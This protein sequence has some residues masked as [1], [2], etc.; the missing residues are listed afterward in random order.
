MEDGSMM[1]L[2]MLMFLAVYLLVSIWVTKKAAGW[3]KAN[4]KKPWLWGGLAA[5]VMYN[6]VFWD[7]IPTVV[8]HK[9]YCA[10]EA[11]FW[12]YK[13]PEQWKAE[14]PGVMETLISN[15]GQVSDHVEDG[16]SFTLT[17]HMNQRFIHITNLNGRLPF[18]RWRVETEIVDGKTKEVLAREIDFSTSQE[19]SEGG[20]V[21]WK[22]WLYSG[23]TGSRNCNTY[24]HRDSG[25]MSPITNELEGK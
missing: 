10:T 8:T 11:G 2:I 6:L 23:F 13:T 19:R 25:D 24:A 16:E 4:N 15:K 21:G 9:Y 14:N 1:G 3:A 20:W 7:W 17:S 18:N 22:F 5:F 12:V